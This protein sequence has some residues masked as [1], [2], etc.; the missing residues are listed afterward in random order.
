MQDVLR[1]TSP[2]S[3]YQRAR[4]GLWGAQARQR[5]ES[6]HHRKVAADTQ[7]GFVEGEA[8]RQQ[9]SLG[10][11]LAARSATGRLG[12]GPEGSPGQNQERRGRRG[13]RR[14]NST[15]VASDWT[16]GGSADAVMWRAGAGRVELG[17]RTAQRK[18]SQ[19][20]T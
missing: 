7:G 19:R 3:R 14:W 20:R 9:R 18:T 1:R 17:R 2:A 13:E 15:T 11:R 10:L 4:R 8:G 12:V 16:G 5:R 6:T